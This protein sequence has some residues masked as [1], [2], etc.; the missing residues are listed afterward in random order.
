MGRE[1]FSKTD[2]EELLETAQEI[3][4]NY[5]YMK[6]HKK[7]LIEELSH[8]QLNEAEQWVVYQLKS[9]KL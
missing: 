2:K 9:I 7:A 6:A 1:R 4:D 5:N 8:R 3:I